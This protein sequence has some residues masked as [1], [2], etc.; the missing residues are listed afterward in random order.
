MK[1]INNLKLPLSFKPIFWS[2]DFDSINFIEDKERIIINTVNYGNWEHWQW[3]IKRYGQKEV[4]KRMKPVGTVA[5]P[6]AAFLALLSI[7]N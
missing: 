6:Q 5:I 4:K 2:Y 7:E 3:I 1:K